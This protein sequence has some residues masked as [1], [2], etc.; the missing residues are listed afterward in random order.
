MLRTLSFTVLCFCLLQPINAANACPLIDGL[1]DY[2]C[3]Q[4]GKISITGDSFVK[5]VGDSKSKGGYVGRV[6]DNFANFRF[7]ETGVNGVTTA[8]LLSNFK[9]FLPR[10]KTT[11]NRSINSDIMIIDVGRN[12]YW[13]KV[14][15]S[16]VVR[17]IK[18][19]VKF[20]KSNLVDDRADAAPK[21]FVSAL[22]PTK[23]SFQ[24]PFIREVNRLLL[25]Q[26]GAKLP[27]YLRFDKLSQNIV[28]EDGLHPTARGYT[29]IAS[30]LTK[31]IN[32]TAQKQMAKS[33]KDLDSD[34]IYDFFETNR[35]GTDPEVADTLVCFNVP[36]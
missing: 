18:R 27:V 1:I 34:G 14:Q 22:L 16:M 2:N 8:R 26:K 20:L 9:R 17:N 7:T 25:K 11:Y 4:A 3:N 30:F 33:R 23:R 32:G 36:I 29:K 28:G 10:H 15:P 13:Q 31:F 19:L 6:E 24:A 21:I 12:D 35:Y 5:G